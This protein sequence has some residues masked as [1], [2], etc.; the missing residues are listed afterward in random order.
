[1]HVY[2]DGESHFIRSEAAVKEVFG[3]GETLESIAEK[4]KGLSEEDGW[5]VLCERQCKFFWDC[6][7]ITYDPKGRGRIKTAVRR[8]VYFTSF[9]GDDDA[10]HS[11]KVTLREKG[12]EPRI[13]KEPSQLAKQREN[14]LRNCR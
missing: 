9:S 3:E 6:K 1:M 2:I 7:A 8:F 10:L 14:V 12:F 5:R 11:L 4:S 13:V